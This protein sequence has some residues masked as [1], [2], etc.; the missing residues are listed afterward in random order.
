MSFPWLLQSPSYSYPPAYIRYYKKVY[1]SN[2][3]SRNKAKN[4]TSGYDILSLKL[5]FSHFGGRMIGTTIG[6]FSNDFLFYGNKLFASTF[7]T[8]IEPSTKGNLMT[9]WLWNLVNVVVELFGYYLAAMLIDHK[10][11]GRRRM[12]SVGFLADGILFLI[13]ASELALRLKDH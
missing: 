1:T 9:T 7:I 10:F 5:T 8:I 6:W 13:P 4:N 12:Q 11:Y 2:T 3:L